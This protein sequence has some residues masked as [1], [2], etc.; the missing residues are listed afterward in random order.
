MAI[1]TD[2]EGYMRHNL[3]SQNR[4]LKFIHRLS[5]TM[6]WIN[7]PLNQFFLFCSLIPPLLIL[8][9]V[10]TNARSVPIYDDW[11]TNVILAQKTIEGALTLNDLVAQHLEHRYL[12]DSI[13]TVIAVKFTG[14]NLKLGSFLGVGLVGCNFVILINWC[15][16]DLPSIVSAMLVP[17]SAL[18]FSFRQ[19][20]SWLWPLIANT[21]LCVF[22]FLVAVSVLRT[23]RR[24]WPAIVAAAF[25]SVCASF[26][27]AAG[28]LVWPILLGAL[29]VIGY[30]Q[31]R[32]YVFWIFAMAATYGLYFNNFHFLPEGLNTNLA[33]VSYYAIGFLG[34][35]FVWSN[36][37]LARNVGLTGLIMLLVSVVY[38][39]WNGRS[40]ADIVV[41][42]ALA[43]FSIGSA[44]VVG[45]GRAH[46]P[47]QGP[48]RFLSSR[49][50]PLS[51]PFWIAVIVLSLSTVA[52]MYEKRIT[53]PWSMPIRF[54]VM[55]TFSTLIG[56]F[57]VA[58]IQG[59]QVSPPVNV[60]R[61]L[62]VL[63]Y[64]TTRDTSCLAGLYPVPEALGDR[65]DMLARYHLAVFAHPSPP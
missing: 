45:M 60:N 11:D 7:Q 6:L 56:L 34:G 17:V 23:G 65:I 58:S 10:V 62:C 4:N 22:W 20:I 13:T 59:S 16:R 54:F 33:Q 26:S 19:G 53:Q 47:E 30:H 51:T 36:M 44:I 3:I 8:I 24:G 14:W 15:K 42:L 18:L 49:Y 2:N 48:F 61:E 46:L 28:L 37:Q 41:W 27:M 9:Y 29:W 64:P 12:F 40:L 57:I 21:Y 5:E 32:H 39:L 43:A 31:W 1:P 38:L 63:N 52:I 35:P 55:S 50:V 25:L